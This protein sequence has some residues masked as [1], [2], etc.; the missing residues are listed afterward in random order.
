MVT[1]WQEID[2]KLYSFLD[3][4]VMQTGWIRRDE[5]RYYLTEQGAATGPTEIEGETY[6]FT[7]KGICVR[8]VN[9]NH[10]LS[11]YFIPELVQSVGGIWIDPAMDEP[12]RQMTKD[13]VDAGFGYKVTCGFRSAESQRQLVEAKDLAEQGIGAAAYPGQSEHQLG[14]AVDVI[15]QGETN[16]LAE[17]CWEYGFILRYPEGKESVTRVAPELWHFRYVGREVSMDMRD[18]GL[19]LEE[20]LG[21]V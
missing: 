5:Y 6:Y 21:A 18:S 9:C 16:W 3:S 20:Y 12:L 15:C 17:H 7:P 14:L 1:G 13:C 2:G 11:I 4:G 10:P 8:L 19:C